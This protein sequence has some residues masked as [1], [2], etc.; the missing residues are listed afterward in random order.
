MMEICSDTG[1]EGYQ[2]AAESV[3]LAG[4]QHA[5]NALEGA[6]LFRSVASEMD[7]GIAGNPLFDALGGGSLAGVTALQSGFGQRVL[8]TSSRD[9]ALSIRG[10]ASSSIKGMSLNV[11]D[12]G[13][14]DDEPASELDALFRKIGGRSLHP[15]GPFSSPSSAPSLTAQAALPHGSAATL[16]VPQRSSRSGELPDLDMGLMHQSQPQA[17]QFNLGLGGL[18]LGNV[19]GSPTWPTDSP[20]DE[21]ERNQGAM[22][23]CKEEEGGSIGGSKED[24]P[25][26]RSRTA[27]A[28]SVSDGAQTG[29]KRAK[30]T[31]AK[32]QGQINAAETK[33]KS[34]MDAKYDALFSAIKN[35][36][37]AC[38]A[39]GV[40]TSSDESYILML[41]NC[42]RLATWVI[43]FDKSFDNLPNPIE[44]TGRQ[45]DAYEPS[46]LTEHNDR[47][48]ALISAF[49]LMPVSSPDSLF[50]WH[51]V[52]SALKTFR[53]LDSHE[54]LQQEQSKIKVLLSTWQEL[55][56]A[57][58]QGCKDLATA[59]T[60]RQAAA[61]KKKTQADT[62]IQKAS[63][64][65]K[66]VA[67]ASQAAAS[68]AA[69]AAL[70]TGAL[71]KTS[72]EYN[73]VNGNYPNAR[74]LLIDVGSEKLSHILASF[75]NGMGWDVPWLA[76]AGDELAKILGAEPLKHA[77][78]KFNQSVNNHA[79]AA[80]TSAQNAG[81]ALKQTLKSCHGTKGLMEFV[82]RYLPEKKATLTPTT[83]KSEDS[84]CVYGALGNSHQ[85]EKQEYYHS[86][87]KVLSW[88][89]HLVLIFCERQGFTKGLLLR[90]PVWRR[91]RH[92]VS[93]C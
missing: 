50:P 54:A 52:Y 31:S 6:N 39:Q 34:V 45:S 19:D 55:I 15:E 23:T 37:T 11:S 21:T 75:D 60:K 82:R 48:H 49:A 91:R 1:T 8:S 53:A 28:V 79:K 73:L 51:S 3:T 67:Q 33:A 4:V 43:G 81:R 9:I 84:L 47:K 93:S 27:E 18:G 58:G 63:A 64:K 71:L 66:A 65:A 72:R 24:E 35:A 14:D 69:T 32:L 57:I 56:D 7:S 62:A 36:L 59:V 42:C 90:M 5:Q 22:Q 83:L 26:Q 10:A 61:Q 80:E 70:A 44:A 12:A 2:D 89:K 17:L 87:I 46:V 16:A 92:A 13:S 77:I 85:C 74:P 38:S 41:K 88:F 30:M 68:A 40:D 20:I 78:D 76:D 25:Q 29:N 86:E